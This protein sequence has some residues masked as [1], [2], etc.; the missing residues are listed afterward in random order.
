MKTLI[1]FVLYHLKKKWHLRLNFIL[2]L[3]GHNPRFEKIPVE[4]RFSDFVAS[5][6]LYTHKSYQGPERASV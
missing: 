2:F 3:V 6:S 5:E 4:L 1:F